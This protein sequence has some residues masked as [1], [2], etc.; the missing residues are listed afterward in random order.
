MNPF[1]SMMQ[2]M[3]PYWQFWG[4][5][6]RQW[7]SLWQQGLPSGMPIT[8]LPDMGAMWPQWPTAAWWPQVDAQI[9]PVA[10]SADGSEAARVSMRVSMPGCLGPA[11]MLLIEA[12][13]ARA[14]AADAPKR[15]L[16]A[17]T[18][19]PPAR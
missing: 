2:A 10:S 16:D 12:L 1:L 13:V 8:G 3:N 17:A 9:T 11:E 15:V 6:Q 7:W 5:M 14:P 4:D 19:L 18:L